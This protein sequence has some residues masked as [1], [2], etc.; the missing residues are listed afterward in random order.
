MVTMM[1]FQNYHTD[2]LL[3][4][5]FPKIPC[6]CRIRI[7]LKL[8]SL[9]NTAV[10]QLAKIKINTAGQL[11][12]GLEHVIFS[13]WNEIEFLVWKWTRSLT[14]W[15]KWNTKKIIY[16]GSLKITWKQSTY[17][18]GPGMRIRITV[19]R[20]RIQITT[21]HFNAEPDPDKLPKI[22]QI[23]ADSAL[24]YSLISSKQVH[25]QYTNQSLAV[26]TEP[27]KPGPTQC[28]RTN[29][30]APKNPLSL[31]SWNRYP[32]N[33]VFL[34]RKILSW[35]S[36]IH[37]PQSGSE[38][39]IICA[40]RY[41]DPAPEPSIKKQKKMRKTLISAEKTKALKNHCL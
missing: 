29:P 26:L 19:I 35:P 38:S 36:T 28:T 31:Y 4:G 33:S 3:I 39:V 22:K 17:W 8:V 23:H 30:E 16:L 9:I 18:Y 6:Q 7:V 11:A 37:N 25:P 40:N 10:E 1:S 15:N 27:C 5:K 24:A 2:R 34:I 41:P 14:T 13:G 21:V 32:L 12:L 20:I